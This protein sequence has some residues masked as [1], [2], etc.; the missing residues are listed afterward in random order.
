MQKERS[1]K[2]NNSEAEKKKTSLVTSIKEG[3]AAGAASDLGS[4]LITPLATELGAN[5]L[6]IG[7]L[8]ALSGI[9]S[10]L[11]MIKGDRLMEK[12]SRKSIVTR[13]VLW[14][15]LMWIP[16][17]LLGLLYYKHIL[18][19]FL[20]WAL[21]ILYTILISFGGIAHPAW[22]SWMGD[23]VDEKT[24]G[25]YF[26]KRNVITGTIGVIA[27]LL[28]GWALKYF[29]SVG[30]VFIGF[31]ILFFFCLIF[32][33]ISRSYLKKI[34][35]PKFKLEKKD[36][37]SFW[38]FLKRY[39]DFGKF[40]VYQAFFNFAIMIASPFFAFYMLKNLGFESNYLMYMIVNFA[41]TAFY[42]LFT[43][44]VGRFSDKYGNLGLMYV[45]NILF[46]LNPIIWIFVK[47]P[48]TI[49][50]IPQVVSGL[51]NA[52]MTIGITNYTYDGVSP[53][54]RG[55]CT[56]YTNLLI[57]LG[58]LV[59]SLI[60]GYLIRTLHSS[61]MNSFFIV[62]IIAA[63]ARL[64]VGLFFLPQ[65]KEMRKVRKFKFSDIHMHMH[66]HLSSPLRHLRLG[67]NPI[68]AHGRTGKAGKSKLLSAV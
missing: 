1:R 8:N 55:L 20:P 5:A 4:S 38:A 45:S 33:L 25:K 65:L 21:V 60:G 51:A 11:S 35:E 43:P 59:G 48:L 37:F 67:V 19:G 26:S 7:F 36:Y 39:D 3:S 18:T 56:A 24:K 57:G 13:Y 50:F 27:M 6:H 23:I 32:R 47:T 31:G 61:A 54:K 46:A 17:A 52:A 34:Y 53:P 62:F 58:T 49:I 12:S 30:M 9:S 16:I 41:G 29:K 28:G 10:P 63:A 22:F 40:A 14:Q 64:L 2:V 44:L 66:H 15:A 68:I 42:L